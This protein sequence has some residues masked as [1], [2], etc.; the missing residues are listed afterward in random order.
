VI[1]IGRFP[2]PWVPGADDRGHTHVPILVMLPYLQVCHV[3][4]LLDLVWTSL[5]WSPPLTSTTASSAM[6]EPRR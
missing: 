2:L 6:L 5:R 4:F 3:G 1:P